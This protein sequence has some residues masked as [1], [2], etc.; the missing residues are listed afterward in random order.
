MKTKSRNLLITIL[1]ALA[2]ICGVFAITPLMAFA[3]EP[4]A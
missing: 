1:L 2:F 4:E 3:D